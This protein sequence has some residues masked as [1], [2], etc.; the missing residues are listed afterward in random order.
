MSVL[1]IQQ[2]VESISNLPAKDRLRVSQWAM[3]EIEPQTAYAMFDEACEAGYYDA[4][5][6]ETDDD[7][8]AGRA[9][10]SLD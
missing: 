9:L 2:A 6:K 3:A 10:D 4:V 5:I 8:A 7:F 1:E